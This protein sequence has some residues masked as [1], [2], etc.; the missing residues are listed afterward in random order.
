MVWPFIV[1]SCV[2]VNAFLIL[3][4]SFYVHMYYGLRD[5][6]AI[7]KRRIKLVM[8]M[9]CTYVLIMILAGICIPLLILHFYPLQLP[10]N[11]EHIAFITVMQACN[12]SSFLKFWLVFY[13][14]RLAEACLNNQWKVIYIYTTLLFIYLLINMP[15]QYLDEKY[16]E[17]EWF[18]SHRKTYGS[19]CYCLKMLIPLAVIAC[20]GQQLNK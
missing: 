13:D 6:V 16:G 20:A 18:K 8:F 5:I 9:N 12:C 19:I 11:I 7:K 17:K 4:V 1:Y 14:I 10:W 15:Q 3:T 2:A